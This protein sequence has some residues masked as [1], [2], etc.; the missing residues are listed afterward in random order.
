[1]ASSII[2][3]PNASLSIWRWWSVFMAGLVGGSIGLIAWG[4][5]AAWYRL[6][7][8]LL[9]PLA[10]GWAGSRF[11][12][13]ILILAYFLC[14]AR[15][16]PEGATVFFGEDAPPWFGWTLWLGLSTILTI[17]FAVLWSPSARA[18][19]WGVLAAMGVAVVPP[20]GVIGVL[21]PVAVTGV[22]FPGLGWFGMALG[23]F[24]MGALAGH[25]WRVVSV[26]S[27]LAVAVNA[28]VLWVEPAENSTTWAGMDT[29]FSRLSSGGHEDAG[30]FLDAQR[31]VDVI[32]DMAK[33]IPPGHVV[34][35]PE[36][37]L[38]TLDGISQYALLDTETELSARGSRLLVGAEVG[39]VRGGKSQNVVVVLG[40]KSGEDRLAVQGI[41]APFAMWRPWAEDGFAANVFGHANVIRVADSKAAF[42]VC[43][44]Q[45]LAYSVLWA[46]SRSPDLLVGV[47]NIWWAR[48]TSI[49]AIQ[50]QMM[51]SFAR[52]FGVG[53]VISRNN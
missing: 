5:D 12:A 17:P 13:S 24:L 30:Q 48:T 7:G 6:V 31:R 44:E 32:K 11:K 19:A 36:T 40:A 3:G 28:L 33:A 21:S 45:V 20:L 10:W 34:V 29:H 51:G 35:F 18:R 27:A 16:L 42:L 38:G 39:G 47:S 46:M 49:P 1:M 23:L 22:L 15:G 43:Y 26:V 9:L 4:W 25:Y 41:P 14:G 37:V 2:E 52:L 50:R 8:L 53:L